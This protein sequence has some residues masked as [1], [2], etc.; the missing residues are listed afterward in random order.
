[1]RGDEEPM[2][3]SCPA[4]ARERL[5]HA[6]PVRE[7]AIATVRTG[8]TTVRLPALRLDAAT[9]PDVRDLAL[10]CSGP[11]SRLS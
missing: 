6:L 5:G 9:R 1:M 11:P 4:L 8:S 2:R 3:A 7:T 10:A